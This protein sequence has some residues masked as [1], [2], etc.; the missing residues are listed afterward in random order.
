MKRDRVDFGQWLRRAIADAG[1]NQSALSRRIGVSTASINR[2]VNNERIPQASNFEPLARGLGLT[3][4]EVMAAAGVVDA[5]SARVGPRAR[6][7]D[8]LEWLPDQEIEVIL[9]FSEFQVQRARESMRPVTR[10][11]NSCNDEE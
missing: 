10:D 7:F 4:D 6:L 2:W 1:T 3:K 11:R 8:L 5:R 9:A